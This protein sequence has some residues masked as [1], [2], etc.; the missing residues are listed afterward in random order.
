MREDEL[1]M[2][3]LQTIRVNG[4]SIYLLEH[5]YTLSEL[6][7]DIDSLKEQGLVKSVDQNLSLTKK[8]ESYFY[9]MNN[10]LG[11]KGLYRYTSSMF[12]LKDEPMPLNEVYVPY[13]RRKGKK[14]QT[15]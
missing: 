6:A 4:N 11:R 3:L 14:E 13:K 7:R 15:F 9:K 12:S 8:G 1:M 2:L 10:G 5:G